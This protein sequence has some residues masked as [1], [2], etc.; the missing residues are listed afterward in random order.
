MI[1][2]A[3]QISLTSSSPNHPN[4]TSFT[5]FFQNLAHLRHHP[6]IHLQKPLISRLINQPFQVTQI[7]NNPTSP[8]RIHH[9]FPLNQTPQLFQ[10]GGHLNLIPT[11]LLLYTNHLYILQY[12]FV[13]FHILQHLLHHLL[14]LKFPNQNRVSLLRPRQ[15]FHH[16]FHIIPLIIPLHPTTTTTNTCLL[17][18]PRIQVQVPRAGSR[19]ETQPDLRPGPRTGPRREALFDGGLDGGARKRSL[20]HDPTDTGVI[21]DGD[22]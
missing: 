15:N 7:N 10:L 17:L 3:S 6:S 20:P 4:L 2:L 19:P 18:Q 16:S 22:Y 9:H 8:F 5:K 13:Y 11:E 14:R 1:N 12:S 21:K